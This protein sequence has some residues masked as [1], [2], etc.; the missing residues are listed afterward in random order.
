MR[1]GSG[2]RLVEAATHL[3]IKLKNESRPET[4]ETLTAVSKG[5]HGSRVQSPF[6]WACF[7]KD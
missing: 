4:S 5:E 7:N 3:L 6:R 2:E 1:P